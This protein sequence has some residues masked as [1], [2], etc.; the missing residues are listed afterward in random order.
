LNCGFVEAN[1]VRL[2]HFDLKKK[3]FFDLFQFR[4]HKGENL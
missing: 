4:T 1:G 3:F 2:T